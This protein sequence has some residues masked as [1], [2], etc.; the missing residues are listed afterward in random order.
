MKKTP[1]LSINLLLES[2][3][4]KFTQAFIMK[5][6]IFW[7]MLA[8]LL[9]TAC[10]QPV[11]DPEVI[12][13]QYWHLVQTG[14]YQAAEQLVSKNTRDEFRQNSQHIKAINH[15]E[16][17]NAQTSIRTTL[18]PSTRHPALNQPFSTVLVLEKGKWKI[19]A[20]QTQVPPEP[21]IAEQQRQKHI[22][23]FSKSIK[24]N[25]DSI[26]ETVREGLKQLNDVLDTGSKDMGDSLLKAMKELDKSMRESIDKMKQ[27][28]APQKQPP[29]TQSDTD[30]GEGII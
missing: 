1:I 26:D 12:A 3:K 21:S 22:D 6:N 25:I 5:K 11:D 10:D 27:R 30:N 7:L 15:V 8:T 29:S 4:I 24:Q 9:I 18:N 28:K 20:A 13:K 2:K 17:D 14:D 16:L 19:D 23:D